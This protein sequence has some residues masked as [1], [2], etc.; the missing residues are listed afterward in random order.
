MPAIQPIQPPAKP[1]G[2]QETAESVFQSQ[3]RRGHTR[4]AFCRYCDCHVISTWTRSD[5][6]TGQMYWA[7]VCPLHYLDEVSAPRVLHPSYAVEA[8]FEEVS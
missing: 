5:W 2:F 8:E 3:S 7:E 1:R 4:L 6:G